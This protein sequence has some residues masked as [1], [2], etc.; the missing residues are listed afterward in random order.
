MSFPWESGTADWLDLAPSR[1]GTGS[2]GRLRRVEE[3][4]SAEE[5]YDLA[6]EYHL[7]FEDWWEA[8]KGH[9]EID[10]RLLLDLGVHPGA[11][12]LDC[13]CGIG[14]Q[15]LPLALRGYRVLGTDISAAA[16]A[17]AQQEAGKRDIPV[18]FAVCDVRNVGRLVPARFEAA[19]ACDNSLAHLLT[20]DDLLGA[21]RSIRTCL[22]P[23]GV[24]LASL[25]DDSGYYQP[26]VT[27]RAT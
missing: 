13:T 19:F 16:I 14:T 5:F 27:A 2:C 25:R 9:G 1:R 18:D 21:L 12:L 23:G 7:L 15:A 24:F 6:G 8:A 11:R 4:L 10:A 20:E 22:V 3:G 17:R 26:I